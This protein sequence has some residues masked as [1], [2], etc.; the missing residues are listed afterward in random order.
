MAAAGG[1]YGYTFSTNAQFYEARDLATKDSLR[2]TN[3]A[4]VI[5]SVALGVAGI[6]VGYAGVIVDANPVIPWQF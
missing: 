4:L 2:A 5:T 6:G 3:N 1:V